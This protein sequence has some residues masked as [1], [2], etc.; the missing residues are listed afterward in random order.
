M[1]NIAI[2][3][4][5]IFVILQLLVLNT[6]CLDYSRN[7]VDGKL[8]PPEPGFFE[9]DK[10]IGGIDS[11]NDGVRDDIER[12]INREFPGEENYNK[13]MAWK[14]RAKSIRDVHLKATTREEAI[15]YLYLWNDAGVCS[16]YVYGVLESEPLRNKWDFGDDLMAKSNDT[17]ERLGRWMFADQSFAGQSH[18]MPPY[19]KMPLKCNFTIK[20]E[21][22]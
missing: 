20:N 8:E 21:V 2:K 12:W 16:T 17:K 3:T 7:M 13:R 10:T 18:T 9:N 19:S 1:Q 4:L 15:K 22:K 11:N 14:Q 5:K 6:S